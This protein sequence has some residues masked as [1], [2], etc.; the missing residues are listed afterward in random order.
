[1]KIQLSI[2]FLLLL[3]RSLAAMTGPSG[4]RAPVDSISKRLNRLIGQIKSS[5][6][7]SKELSS[8]KQPRQEKAQRVRFHSASSKPQRKLPDI[9]EILKQSL[10]NAVVINHLRKQYKSQHPHIKSPSK[11]LLHKL[12]DVSGKLFR[13][14]SQQTTPSE[15]NRPS[16]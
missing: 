1:M 11:H 6:L 2:L 12:A 13:H 5:N 9:R 14:L 7:F 15:L 8:P 4:P 10:H 3:E 16:T